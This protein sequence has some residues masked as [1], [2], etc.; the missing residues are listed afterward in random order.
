MSS[1]DSVKFF[2]NVGQS[3]CLVDVSCSHGLES[4]AAQIVDGT[5]LFN[6]SFDNGG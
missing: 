6:E 3:P 1:T 4:V 2:R 5:S